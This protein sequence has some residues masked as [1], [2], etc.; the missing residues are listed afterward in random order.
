MLLLTLETRSLIFTEVINHVFLLRDLYTVVKAT[1]K[2]MK[3][4]SLVHTFNL[5]T[6]FL[7]TFCQHVCNR[8]TWDKH[9]IFFFV[10]F[11]NRSG[12]VVQN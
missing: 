9:Q 5:N 4:L 1:C 3:F 12:L 8:L 10:Q 7:N 6:Q 2:P 11:L